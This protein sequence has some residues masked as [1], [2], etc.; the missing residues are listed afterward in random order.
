RDTSAP[1]VLGSLRRSATRGNGPERSLPM[2]SARAAAITFAL[3]VAVAFVIL[4]VWGRTQWF[5]DF[6][7]ELLRR[8]SGGLGPLFQPFGAP[9]NWET[10]PI[11][12]WRVLWWFFGLRS[13][14]PYLMVGVAGHLT[15]AVLLRVIMRRIGVGPWI[16][17][18]V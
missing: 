13:Y 3:V 15:V 18:I 2:D 16:A 9:W 10:V 11:L 5:V 12:V 17:T 1:V 6:E 4:P 7:W 8:T 14:L